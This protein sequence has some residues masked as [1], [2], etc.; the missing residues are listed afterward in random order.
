MVLSETR[1]LQSD[2]TL[3]TAMSTVIANA[4]ANRASGRTG[5]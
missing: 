4:L 1:S 5:Q 2:P 3:E